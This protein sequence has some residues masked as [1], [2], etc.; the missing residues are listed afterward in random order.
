MSGIFQKL[1]TQLNQPEGRG[2]DRSLGVSVHVTAWHGMA[3]CGSCL[4]LLQVPKVC[5]RRIVASLAPAQHQEDGD[6]DCGDDEHR[7][8]GR[9][10]ACTGCQLQD[11]IAMWEL[12]CVNSGGH[13]PDSEA[14]EGVELPLLLMMAAVQNHSAGPELVRLS[15]LSFCFL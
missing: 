11:S 1:P 8:E 5:A 13:S 2:G 7:D 14:D 4:P 3:W 9:D 10:H 6:V 12:P 15:V